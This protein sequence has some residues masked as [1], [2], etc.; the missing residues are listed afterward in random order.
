MRTSPVQPLLAG[1]PYTAR[2]AAAE[3][4]TPI[5]SGQEQISTNVSIVFLIG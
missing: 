2:A 1:T 5:I 3:T 4:A